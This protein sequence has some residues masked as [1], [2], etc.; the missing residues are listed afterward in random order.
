HDILNWSFSSAPL[1]NCFTYADF[2]SANGLALVGNSAT[3]AGSLRLT[4][5]AQDQLG[6]AWRLDK[7]Q[8]SGGFDTRFQFR[9]DAQGSL[10]GTPS[11]ADGI[12]FAVQNLGTATA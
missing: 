12:V 8:C 4:P 1:S 9:M 6:N 3:V 2:S 5:A 10:P 7:Q 11:G